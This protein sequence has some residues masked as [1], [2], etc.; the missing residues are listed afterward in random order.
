MSLLKL[1]AIPLLKSFALSV[2]RMH[3]SL[4]LHRMEVER[5]LECEHT[6]QLRALFPPV[7]N[8]FF[9][10]STKDSSFLPVEGEFLH[11]GYSVVH[12]IYI[13][14]SNKCV[15]FVDGLSGF[16]SFTLFYYC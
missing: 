12:N 15:C 13:P 4:K 3:S 2:V 8:M 10:A 1:F 9:R 16:S 7:I 6:T 14:S 5:R 11:S